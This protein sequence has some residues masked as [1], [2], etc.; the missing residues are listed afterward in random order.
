MANT[1]VMKNFS[2]EDEEVIRAFLFTNPHGNDGFVYP[3][4]LVAGEELSPLM[5]A[6][7]RTHAPTQ[8][9]VL[10]FLD[11]A[12]TE[13]TRAMLQYIRPLMDIF[14]KPDGTL[15]ISR[16]TRDFNRE[17]VILHG[18]SSIKEGT[19]LF[20][21]CENISDIGANKIFGH[22][23][24]KPQGKST[25]YVSY[26]KVL[27]MVLDDED[28]K[29]LPESDRF[30]EHLAHINRRYLEVSEL[31][32]DRVF[33]SDQ[34]ARVVEYLR[35]PEQVSEE[36]DKWVANRRRIDTEFRLSAEDIDRERSRI[37]KGLEDDSVRK[38]IGKFVLDYSRVFLPAATRTSVVFSADARTL[39]EVISGM[40]SSPRIE[41]RTRGHSL[42]NEAKKIAPVLLG[43]NS[44]IHYD[45]WTA[46]NEAE[47]RSCVDEIVNRLDCNQRL[48][49]SVNVLTPHNM[50]MYT[51]RFNAALIAFAYSD[52]PLKNIS[53]ALT[54][55]EV[56]RVLDAAHRFRGE[57]DVLHPAISHGGLMLELTM[58]YHSFRDIYRHRRGSRTTQI[59]TTRLGFETPEIFSWA[60]IE[61][62][63][64]GDMDKSAELY[65]EARKIDKHVA[66]KIVPFGFNCRS[67][68]SW[69]MNQ[70]GYV[71][72]LRSNI[73]TGNR[74]YVKIAR[75][76][77][78][79][80]GAVMP[81]TA[82]FLR[83]DSRE[84]PAELWKR[85]Y[86]WY[87]K[88]VDGK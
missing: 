70:I 40:I 84:Y 80:V 18:H 20:G 48:G 49:V 21:H 88:V 82:R 44:H 47:L 25:R 79:K 26:K 35:R 63:Y 77:V 69:Q 28:V 39:E 13:K 1:G 67:L 81:I 22:P 30:F 43:G 41:D 71:G 12:K 24:N 59:L 73:E 8:D 17:H 55:G 34:T 9:R 5:S 54:D 65:E 33:R 74:S 52:L 50:E 45:L 16:R 11:T 76:I 38:D 46:K 4:E 78:E 57:F 36:L 68:Q 6:I 61:E 87:D 19:T 62:E 14:R 83:A 86:G 56:E 75:E 60:G 27:D 29:Q 23:L 53:E 15:D 72:R 51:D 10:Q 3:Q 42:W 58:P 32:T 31:L 2:F 7:S 85:G 64:S 66:E 37:L